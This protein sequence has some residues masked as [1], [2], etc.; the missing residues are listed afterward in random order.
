[1]RYGLADS[2]VQFGGRFEEDFVPT[3]A[4]KTLAVRFESL[5]CLEAALENWN[6]YVREPWEGHCSLAKV[7]VFYAEDGTVWAY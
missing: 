3:G 5:D 4:D 6:E 2:L 1:M 7:K